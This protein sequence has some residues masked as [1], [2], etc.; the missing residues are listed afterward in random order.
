MKAS[1]FKLLI[2]H[3]VGRG[4]ALAL[5]EAG[6]DAVFAGDVDPHLSD[7]AILDWAVREGRL[8][9]TQD[10]D[11]GVL[12]YRSGQA[13]AGIL[14]LHMADAT[15]QERTTTL[16]WLLRHYAPDLVGH[17]SVYENERLRIR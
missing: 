10:K 3:N 13:H 1:D 17:F 11:F 6:Y 8:I 12:V 5:R 16:L 2:D 9:V 15:R 14:L 4:V 7:A